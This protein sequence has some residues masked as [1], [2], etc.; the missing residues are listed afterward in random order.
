MNKSFHTI[1][2]AA[3]VLYIFLLHFLPHFFLL[4]SH[5]VHILSTCIKK[6]L[7]L[8]ILLCTSLSLFDSYYLHAFLA[9]FFE[10]RLY[11]SVIFF[12]PAPFEWMLSCI[13]YKISIAIISTITL[14]FYSLVFNGL[15]KCMVTSSYMWKMCSVSNKLEKSKSSLFF[16][17][18]VFT[19]QN[20]QKNFVVSTKLG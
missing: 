4:S 20:N 14:A 6:R 13:I 1:V 15:F 16:L 9:I 19:F 10:L 17:C 7:K 5:S 8:K 11:V 12:L 3:S 2:I 18:S